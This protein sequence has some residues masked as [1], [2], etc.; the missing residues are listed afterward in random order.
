MAGVYDYETFWE[1]LERNQDLINK[2]LQVSNGLSEI[3]SKGVKV[4]PFFNWFDTGNEAGYNFANRFF[5]KNEVIVKPNEYIYFENG[6]VIKY[7]SDTEIVKQRIERAKELKGIVPEITEIVDNFY[8]Y[9]FVEGITLAKINDVTI[10]K[11]FLNFCED[12]IWKQKTLSHEELQ[13]F[14]ILCNEFYQVKTIQRIEKLFRENEIKDQEEIING[15]KV[16]TL[17]ELISQ[18]NWEKLSEG[19][20]VTFH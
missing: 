17:R 2:E 19:I 5:N 14:K 7:F 9:N 18:I 11:Q 15:E 8:A 3:I 10:F 1:G 16:P 13:D 12:T 6:K 4:I 20:P